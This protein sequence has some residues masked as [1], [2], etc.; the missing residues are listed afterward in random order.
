MVKEILFIPT[1][2]IFVNVHKSIQGQETEGR[3]HNFFRKCI[4][5]KVDYQTKVVCI[6]PEMK[7]E[8]E[9]EVS[10]YTFQI[11]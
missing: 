1:K 4:I 9:K 5:Y 11:D 3:A 6:S 7:C 8:L 2:D 10:F